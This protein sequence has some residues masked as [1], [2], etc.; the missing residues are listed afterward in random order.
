MHQDPPLSADQQPFVS[1]IYIHFQEN[2]HAVDSSINYTL[3]RPILFSNTNIT[4]SKG[5]NIDADSLFLRVFDKKNQLS[6]MDF[7]RKNI[8]IYSKCGTSSQT[9]PLIAAS[10]AIRPGRVMSTPLT[11]SMGGS[12]SFSIALIKSL[13]K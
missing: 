4:I 2:L 10:C 8:E 7:L 5:N 1:S 11:T 12:V 3:H 13:I 9:F 6:K